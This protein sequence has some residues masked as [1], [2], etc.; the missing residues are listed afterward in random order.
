MNHMSERCGPLCWEVESRKHE[1]LG[2]IKKSHHFQLFFEK[3]S[4]YIDQVCDG[5]LSFRK[6]M[7][8]FE[9][10]KEKK[11]RLL[12]IGQLWTWLTCAMF[13]HPPFSSVAGRERC[14]PSINSLDSLTYFWARQLDRAFCSDSKLLC[15][16][17]SYSDRQAYAVV[18][19]FP[20]FTFV[21]NNN[22]GKGT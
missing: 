19:G 3:S 16:I 4:K 18:A 20:T 17:R 15:W 22:K 9:K 21:I 10:A 12:A 5:D 6:L 14:V 13:I 7:T 8:L 11:S 1:N 2:N